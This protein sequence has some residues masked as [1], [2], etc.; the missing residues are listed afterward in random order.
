MLVLLD[1]FDRIEIFFFE[2]NV[3]INSNFNHFKSRSKPD[4]L[5]DISFFMTL[6]IEINNLFDDIRYIIWNSSVCFSFK[7]FENC[8]HNS[9]IFLEEITKVCT[10]ININTSSDVKLSNLFQ[11]FSWN[12]KSFFA[13]KALKRNSQSNTESIF[14]FCVN[15]WNKGIE[16]FFSFFQW[17]C[18]ELFNKNTDLL[19]IFLS[20]SICQFNLGLH[21]DV[22]FIWIFILFGYF[23]HSSG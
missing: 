8:I 17:F 19:S 1:F 2:M 12:K 21:I 23:F 6:T 9:C 4:Q 18:A 14:I 15:L 11:L 7:S 20:F 3:Y 10:D 22:F 5:S 13:S 16:E